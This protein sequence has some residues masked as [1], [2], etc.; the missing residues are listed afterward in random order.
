M[1][2]EILTHQ[3]QKATLRILFSNSESLI[4]SPRAFNATQT[5]ATGPMGTRL[6]QPTPESGAAKWCPIFFYTD[7]TPWF[8]FPTIGWSECR[9][10]KPKNLEFGS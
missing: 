4:L 6:R 7:Q 3:L 1:D 10:V 9:A 5:I 2:V 8:L